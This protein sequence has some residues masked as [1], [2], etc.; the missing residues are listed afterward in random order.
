[1]VPQ[2]KWF[3]S[4]LPYLTREVAGVIESSLFVNLIRGKK[5]ENIG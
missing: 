2:K 5:L 1:V 4:H 3:V